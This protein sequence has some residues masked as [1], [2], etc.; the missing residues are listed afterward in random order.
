MKFTLVTRTSPTS[1]S[2]YS[3]KDLMLGYTGKQ[4]ERGAF[5]GRADVADMPF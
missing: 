2:P 4:I 3:E 1:I 5:Y